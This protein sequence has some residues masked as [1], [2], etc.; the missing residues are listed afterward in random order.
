MVLFALGVHRL[1]DLNHAAWLHGLK[2]VAVAVVA[3]AV[4]NM[5]THLCP[6]WPRRMMAVSA[7]LLCLSVPSA[8]GQLGAIVLGA[9]IGWV[10]LTAEARVS[11]S[12][13]DFRISRPV[14]WT[15]LVLF[16][17]FLGLSLRLLAGPTGTSWD[18]VGAFYRSGS[19]VFGGGHVVL[20]LLQ[21]A[22]CLP[23]WVSIDNFLAGYGAAQAMPGPLFSLAAYLGAISQVWTNP[24][25]GG[26]VCLL[27]IYLPSFLL[28]IGV[29]PF[30]EGLRRRPA[31][32]SALKGVNA[33]VVGLLLAA[34]YSPV[35]TSAI[36]GVADFVAAL[37]A[38][39]ALNF[40]KTPAWLVVLSGALL[41]HL[42]TFV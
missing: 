39:L 19:L 31:V 33:A 16:W 18:L 42:L 24:W 40:G 9:L 37:L 6:D 14:S 10:W 17:L 34:L 29:L 13:R 26:L 15:A 25:I 22:V 1:G 21:R 20:P 7:A 4:W 12:P 38:F 28:L 41:A 32:Q 23:G 27:A 35:W 30:W 5:T 8:A 2:I 11:E 36:F 3:H